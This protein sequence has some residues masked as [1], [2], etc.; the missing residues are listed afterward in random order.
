MARTRKGPSKKKTRKR[1]PKPPP[2]RFQLFR[3][4]LG[5][6]VLIVLVVAAGVITHHIVSLP[7]PAPVVPAPDAPAPSAPAYPKPAFEIYPDRDIPVL[8]RLPESRTPNR[9]AKPKVAIIIDDLGYDPAI[10][11]RFLSLGRPI[12]FSILPHAPYTRKIAREADTMGVEIMLHLPME[13]DEYP[14]VNPGPGAL[15]SA[16]SPDELIAQLERNLDVIPTVRGVNN[17]MGSRLTANSSQLYQIFSILKQRDL[18]FIDSRTTP[19]TLCRPSAHMFKLRFSERDIFLDHVQDP[20]FI[21]RQSQKLIGIAKRH[22]QAI[23]IAHP[24][25]L[26]FRVLR[27]ILPELE[28]DMELVPASQVVHPAG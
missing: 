26:T 8:P 12:T 25:R 14:H 11:E 28:K 7:P 3:V 18:Y 27:D 24:N 13:P 4:V 2:L 1:S 6:V 22:G 19:N 23:G 10:A 17:H 5:L 9:F 21:R 16:M 15:M 20:D